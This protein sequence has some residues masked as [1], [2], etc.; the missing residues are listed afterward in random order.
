MLRSPV[1]ERGADF[2][3]GDEVSAH[4]LLWRGSGSVC[5]FDRRPPDFVGVGFDEVGVVPRP[6]F[7]FAHDFETEL[8]WD[9]RRFP[10]P[11]CTVAVF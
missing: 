5:G 3:K 7:V 8:F 6:F 2:L 4:P 11:P 1:R 10:V 9:F